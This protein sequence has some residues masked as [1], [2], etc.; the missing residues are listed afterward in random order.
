MMTPPELPLTRTA[1]AAAPSRRLG[2][3]H[4]LKPAAWRV[5]TPA[6]PI[7]VRDAAHMGVLVWLGRWQLRRERRALERLADLA[8]VPRV[9]G[10]LDRDAFAM[11]CLP[12]RPLDRETF[13]RSPRELTEALGALLG[14]LHERGVFHLDPQARGN[15]L[16]DEGRV[17]LVD[18]GAA[19]A[20]GRLAR[21]LFGRLLA[22]SDRQA[23]LKYLARWC[24]E[25]LTVEEAR[26]VLRQRR[27]RRLWILTPTSRTAGEQARRR[28]LGVA[29]PAREPR[30]HERVEAPP[31]LA[32]RRR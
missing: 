20:P 17:S 8:D 22:W 18:F 16:V 3:Q 23:P 13:Q 25:Q 30:A 7:V 1:L 19:W 9:L 5:E 4:R 31:R 26:T 24:P 32:P 12:G 11:S 28:L 14:R 15:V 21:R 29:P 6:G 27:L 2:T 10:S